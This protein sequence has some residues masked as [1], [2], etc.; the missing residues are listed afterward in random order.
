MPVSLSPREHEPSRPPGARVPSAAAPHPSA[1]S[2][3]L[4]PLPSPVVVVAP[5]R[6]SI[7]KTEPRPTAPWSTPPAGGCP[8]SARPRRRLTSPPWRLPQDLRHRLALLCAR[9]PT[10]LPD[11]MMTTRTPFPDAWAKA[12]MSD[13]QAKLYRCRLHTLE[14]ANSVDDTYYDLGPR[15]KI[16]T[17]RLHRS[18]LANS[19]YD[20][21]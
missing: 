19:A 15:K 7:S 5:R 9:M 20:T 16:N 11:S 4:H 8:D 2:N 18:G 1:P 13:V 3:P 12:C 17:C 10:P 14:I 6:R 21:Y